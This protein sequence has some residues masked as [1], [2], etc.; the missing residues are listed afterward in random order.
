MVTEY[1]SEPVMDNPEDRRF[2]DPFEYWRNN[3][4]RYSMLA[5]MT[6]QYLS[7]PPSSV[8]SE[9]QPVTKNKIYWYVV[10]VSYRFQKNFLYHISIGSV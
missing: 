8:P 6:K 7:A 5:V 4:E 2:M 10:S 3:K 9:R 1:L